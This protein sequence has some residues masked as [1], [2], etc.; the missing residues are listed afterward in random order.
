MPRL[1]ELAVACRLSTAGL[2]LFQPPEPMPIGTTVCIACPSGES[3]GP[4][5]GGTTC[6]ALAKA[7]A[8]WVALAR[9]AGVIPLVRW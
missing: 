9:S 7:R 3:C 5:I 4:T 2:R 8:S 1:C 6:G